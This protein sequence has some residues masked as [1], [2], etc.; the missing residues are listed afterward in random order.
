MGGTK[1]SILPFG[2][3]ARLAVGIID[4]P[5][6]GEAKADRAFWSPTVNTRE[7]LLDEVVFAVRFECFEAPFEKVDSAMEFVEESFVAGS[8]KASGHLRDR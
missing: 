1:R 2:F 7:D 4:L 6:F 3:A 8:D 5:I